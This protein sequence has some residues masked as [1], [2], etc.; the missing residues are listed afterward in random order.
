M[1]FSDPRLLVGFSKLVSSNFLAAVPLLFANVIAA[2]ALGISEYG[3]IA[4]VL[5]YTKLIDG[6]FNFQSV[7]VLTRFVAETLHSE[8]YSSLKGI[9][10][11]GVLIDGLTAFIACALAVAG[12]PIVGALI[13]LSDETTPF[14]IA[15]CLVIPSRILGV[16]EAILRN[17][18]KFW[19]IGFRQVCLASLVAL[20]WTVASWN[21]LE[22][23]AYL[24]IWLVAEL[25]TNLWYISRAQAALRENSMS[26]IWRAG[27]RAAIRKLEGFWR[28]LIQTNLTFGLRLLSQDAD[29]IVA[30]TFLGPGAA[31]FLRVAKDL[32][33]FLGQIGRPLQ[34]AASPRIS[35]KMVVGGPMSA[36]KYAR[37]IA[38]VCAVLGMV[39]AASSFWWGGAVLSTLFGD[40]YRQAEILTVLLLFA[41]STYL[42]G[43]TLLPLT[44]TLDRTGEF[45]RSV[46]YATLI[47]FTSMFLATPVLG[48]MGIALSH[49]VFELS[50]SFY[51][52][53][54]IYQD[55]PNLEAQYQSAS[56]N[57]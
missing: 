30:G 14:A 16:T 29:I 28:M 26:D 53:R 13:G 1:I 5:A 17:F 44:V 48:L 2:R 41:K 36:V 20:G 4:I 19:T 18:E 21:A 38:A 45:L 22:V 3:Q 34:Q 27:A 25:I 24:L 40:D 47:Y 50:W 39:F 52:W 31:A 8:D 23:G 49:L 15:F 51:N 56:P 57:S 46:V 35:R 7:N 11:A 37:T 54:R 32:A 12:L 9:I 42:S 55:L 33:N 10:K 6:F 43:V